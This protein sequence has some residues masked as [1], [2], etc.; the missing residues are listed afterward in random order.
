MHRDILSELRRGLP[1]DGSRRYQFTGRAFRAIPRLNRPRILDVGCGSGGPTLEL[2]RLSQGEVIGLDIN[3]AALETFAG[4]M[5]EAGLSGRVK[6]VKCS[7]S[8]MDFGDEGFDLI[9]AEGSIWVIGFERG[10]KEWRRFIRPEGYLVVHETVWLRQDPPPDVS[11]YWKRSY[12]GIRTIPENLERI[13]A[14]GYDLVDHFALPEDVWWTEYFGPLETRIQELRRRY[15]G[16]PEVVET[17]DREQREVEM[18]RKS[19]AWYG[20]AF[21]VVQK[22][23][24]A[25]PLI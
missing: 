13:P 4:R 9:W 11:G 10:V 5:R 8:A 16:D 24:R 25:E 19:Q 14:C 12:P 20:S 22:S 23:D 7:M 21:F 17:L 15:G 18:Y 3:G 1:I 6:A 2:A